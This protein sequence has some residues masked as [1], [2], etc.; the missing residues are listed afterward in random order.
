LASVARVSHIFYDLAMS[1]L[2]RRV[3]LWETYEWPS[4]LSLYPATASKRALSH[5]RTMRLSVHSERDDWDVE[6]FN[7]LYEYM[8]G[9]LRILVHAR[10]IQYLTLFVGAYDPVDYPSECTK[11][12]KAV[13]RTAFRI[14]KHVANM[15]LRELWFHPGRETA[16]IE[17]IMTIIERK[18][19]KLEIHTIPLGSW[20]H[21]VENLE[22]M[23]EIE[24]VR[25]HPRDE[26]TDAIFWTALSKLA[27]VTTVTVD[28]V[29][30][31]PTLNLQFPHII[32]LDLRLW[33]PI[34]AREWA[35]SLDAVFK[36]FPSLEKLELFSTGRLEFI[37]ATE[38]LRL[39]SVS[40][41]NLRY[42]QISS[43]LPKGLLAILGRDCVN[44]EHCH[45][46][47]RNDSVDDE[48]LLQLSRRPL[49]IQHLAN[50]FLPYENSNWSFAQKLESNII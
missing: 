16:R 15:D 27:N 28:A 17:D 49:H 2:W 22:R 5:I 12:I 48:D 31:S 30:I 9:C 20:A 40:C 33:W 41:R 1:F 25:I 44:L 4:R 26:E 29:P 47:W 39:S 46:G 23:T 32:N 7:K 10:S 24:L 8:C 6:K 19:H 36:Q 42:V 34:T 21:C 14:L 43:G 35:Y 11:I 3:D 45:Y 38:A 50:R 18:V 37:L 13:N